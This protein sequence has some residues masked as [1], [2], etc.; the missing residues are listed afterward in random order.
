MI[1]KTLILTAIIA[2][3]TT[4]ALAAP[5][6]TTNEKE[7]PKWEKCDKKMPPRHMHH[8][9]GPHMD[10]NKRLNLT[11]EQKE[12]IKKNREADRVKMEPLMKQIKE[13]EDAKREIFKKYEETDAQLIKLNKEIKA[14]KAERRKIMEEN[15]KAFEAMLTKDQK[16][17]LEKIKEEHKKRFDG[18]FKKYEKQ[19]KP[20]FMPV[21]E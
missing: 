4:S 8:K 7:L 10:F 2:L 9:K 17:E 6:T 16:A 12:Q 18:K 3:T 21:G 5:I 19:P 14:L 11:E 15:R 20:R 1:K 13:K